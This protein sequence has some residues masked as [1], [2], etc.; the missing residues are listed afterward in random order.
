[1]AFELGRCNPGPVSRRCACRDPLTG[2]QLGHSCPKL[3]QRRH[4]TWGVRQELPPRADGTRR[5][6]RR[7]SYPSA[8]E[9]QGDLDKVRALL[10]IPDTD[11]TSGRQRLGDLLEH[12]ATT[13]E[14]LPTVEDV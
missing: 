11:D 4:G 13:R 5:T 3:S 8:T 12:V 1:M 7:S 6:F 9:A 2:K 10:A 14:P